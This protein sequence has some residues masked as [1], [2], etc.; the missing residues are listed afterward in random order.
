MVKLTSPCFRIVAGR[1]IT[2]SVSDGFWNFVFRKNMNNVCSTEMIEKSIGNR[3]NKE[4]NSHSSDRCQL[5]SDFRFHICFFFQANISWT[6]L[7]PEILRRINLLDAVAELVCSKH[8]NFGK[9]CLSFRV[10][11]VGGGSPTIRR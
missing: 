1:R 4:A 11:S 10:P 6:F 5:F 7:F 3:V 2:R 8:K 9:I